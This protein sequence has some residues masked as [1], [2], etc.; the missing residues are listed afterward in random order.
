MEDIYLKYIILIIYNHD[1]IFSKLF[2]SCLYMFLFL[3]GNTEIDKMLRFELGQY[4]NLPISSQCIYR[5]L[6]LRISAE[7][8]PGSQ[9][10]GLR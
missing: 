1:I 3:I 10:H 9:V 8:V 7:S 4:P 2:F 5:S 6:R